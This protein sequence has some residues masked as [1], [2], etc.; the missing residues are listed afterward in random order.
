[1]TATISGL[2]AHRMA[3]ARRRAIMAALLD[4]GPMRARQIGDVVGLTSEQVHRHIEWGRRA[5]VLDQHNIVGLTARGIA[6]AFGAMSMPKAAKRYDRA[7][8]VRPSEL[9]EAE[10]KWVLDLY[11]ADVAVE[12]IARTIHRTRA[13][14]AEAIRAATGKDKLRWRS[15]N[16]KDVKV[17]GAVPR[18]P[19]TRAEAM[20]PLQEAVSEA[21]KSIAAGGPGQPGC[22]PKA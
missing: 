20:N 18:K 11:D 16:F 2:D 5:G 21:S 15:L 4:L 14:V 17:P 19:K 9:T 12:Q 22:S 6:V 3:D 10:V 7:S 8:E 1:M 13:K